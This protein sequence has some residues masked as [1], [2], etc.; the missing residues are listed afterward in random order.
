[1]NGCISPTH[2]AS[3]RDF[4]VP[5]GSPANRELPQNGSMSG[6]AA[7]HPELA[8]AIRISHGN[9]HWSVTVSLDTQQ[10][11]IEWA[12]SRPRIDY[13]TI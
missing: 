1:V 7:I 13:C 4:R 2:P 9:V 5:V 12:A 11:L 6:L 8:I 3:D 10:S